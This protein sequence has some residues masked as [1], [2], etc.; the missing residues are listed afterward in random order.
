M[1]TKVGYVTL[2]RTGYQMNGGGVYFPLDELLKVSGMN[3]TNGFKVMVSYLGA[4][5]PL[6]TTSQLI[7]M[8]LGVFASHNL[9]SKITCEVGT[10]AIKIK[11][12][13][14]KPAKNTPKE[15]QYIAYQADG[16]R[17]R[18]RR[19]ICSSKEAK[20]FFKWFDC[21]I[22]GSSKE[23]KIPEE[24]KRQYSR[25]LNPWIETKTTL[26][27]NGEDLV[28]NTTTGK[29]WETTMDDFATEIKNKG[30]D[31]AICK[32]ALVSD[33][34]Q[35]IQ[36]GFAKHFPKKEQILDEYHF[37]EHVNIAAKATF[38]NELERIRWVKEC[39]DLCFEN[40]SEGLL[41]KIQSTNKSKADN[42]E[43]KEQLRLLYNYTERNKQRIRYGYFKE[44]GLPIGSGEIEGRI[45]NMND[46]KKIKSASIRW[47][48]YNLK[49]VIALR[50]VIF[51]GQF[52]DLKRIA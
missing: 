44:L 38:T 34:A 25:E 1:I 23:I 36:D 9:C 26:V 29:T 37:S 27:T 3:V 42:A 32:Q 52:D 43:A 17:V 6:R 20:I 2:L 12:R 49:K 22:S 48:E 45:K 39:F 21:L 41:A 40:N 19:D 31:T 47:R 24:L 30:Y 28:E 14:L 51:N 11:K 46:T 50:T 18:I 33:G 5:Q 35:P 13:D 16:G 7:E 10:K 15:E 4:L 8:F